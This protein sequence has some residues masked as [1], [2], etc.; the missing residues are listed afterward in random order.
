VGGGG[1]GEAGESERACANLP[2]YQE[3][4]NRV[5]YHVQGESRVNEEESATSRSARRGNLV[6]RFFRSGFVIAHCKH[7]TERSAR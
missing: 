5:S 4:R 7:H 3:G 2:G 1:G 6:R